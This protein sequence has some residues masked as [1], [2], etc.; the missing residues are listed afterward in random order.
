MRPSLTPAKRLHVVSAYSA[1]DVRASSKLPRP[2]LG[3]LLWLSAPP[4]IQLLR[5]DA[6]YRLNG[7]HSTRCPQAGPR[8]ERQLRVPWIRAQAHSPPAR[9]ALDT[10]KG[11]PEET[12]T[13]ISH[14]TELLC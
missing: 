4:G 1:V 10:N 2:G 7:E 8:A 13:R 11:Y 6:D 5:A 14:L 9:A 3:C 12:P